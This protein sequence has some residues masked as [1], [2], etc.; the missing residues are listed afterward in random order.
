MTAMESV[1]GEIPTKE[2]PPNTVDM[3]V[4]AGIPG[5]EEN[6]A[7]Y[8]PTHLTVSAGTT[9]A[10]INSDGPIPHTVAIGWLDSDLIGADYPGGN[11]FDSSFMSGGATFEHT[12][13]VQGECDYYCQLHPWMI[14]SVTV[15]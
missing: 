15:E 1:D 10:W 3:P 7:C 9:V 11:G 2:L 6:D 8:T 5:C 13:H 14:D 4:G 12:F